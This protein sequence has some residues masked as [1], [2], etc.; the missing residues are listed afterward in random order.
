M[1]KEQS[2]GK[3]TTRRYSEEEKA[4]AVR[5]VRTLRAELGS[6]HGTVKRVAAQLG[7]G[8]ESVRLWVRQADIDDGHAPEWP[9]R[10]RRGFRDLEQ[11]VRELRR[12]NETSHAVGGQAAA[13]VGVGNALVSS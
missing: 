8:V 7:Y 1:P 6:E 9:R 12:A 4:A 5:M 10:R 2:P 3:P 13:G 11:E